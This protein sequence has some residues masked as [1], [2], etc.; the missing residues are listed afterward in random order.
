MTCYDA[1]V[2]VADANLL[3]GVQCST[4][5]RSMGTVV[6]VYDAGN[7]GGQEAEPFHC[8]QHNLPDAVISQRYSE[9]QQRRD[10]FY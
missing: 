7:R 2:V 10:C 8:L 1:I 5:E 4:E 6:H 3:K 9:D